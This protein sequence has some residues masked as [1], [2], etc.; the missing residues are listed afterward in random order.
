MTAAVLAVTAELWWRGR[1]QAAAT[2]LGVE[3]RFPADLGDLTHMLL[4]HDT[5]LVLV[6][7]HHPRIGFV[8]AIRL[9]RGT[10]WD[11]R[12]VCFG[13]HTDVERIAKAKTVG[14]TEVWPN[15]ELDRRLP[16]LLAAVKI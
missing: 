8:E 10:R 13:H 2:V 5:R 7:L 16:E 15:S 11:G 12:L 9:V 1:I 6:D 3:A 4:D 14:A